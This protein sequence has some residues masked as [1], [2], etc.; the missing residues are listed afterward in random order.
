M[1]WC[2][3]ILLLV[4]PC[5]SLLAQEADTSKLEQKTRWFF[6]WGWNRGVFTKSDINFKGDGYDFTLKKVVAHDRQ[7]PFEFSTYLNPHWFA[8]P[9]TNMRLGFY[10]NEKYNVSVASDHMKYIVDTGQT[11]ERTGYISNIGKAY[12]G[13]FDNDSIELEPFFLKYEHKDGLNYVNFRLE[14]TDGLFNYDRIEKLNIQLNYLLGAEV[15]MLIPKTNVTLMNF[16]GNDKYYFSGYGLSLYG[17]ISIT[18]NEHFFIQSEVKG[19]F[20][21]LPSVRTTSSKAD[22]ASQYFFFG[23]RNI[24]FGSNFNIG[25]KKAKRKKKK[26]K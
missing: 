20:F 18:F 22:K 3:I 9:Q 17:G 14:R 12:D 24:L 7:T 8:I 13:E 21:H 11:V 25:P 16:P 15:G 23:Q 26:D 19:G 1:K 6:Y 4:F 2:T 5:Y 10:I